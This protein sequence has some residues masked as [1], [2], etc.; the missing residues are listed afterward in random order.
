[1]RRASLTSA[2]SSR[3][4]IKSKSQRSMDA[5]SPCYIAAFGAIN[6]AVRR[7]FS[8][9]LLALFGL[10]FVSP[11]FALGPD[12]NIGLPACCRR[13]GRHQCMTM[14][15]GD[16][17]GS[18]HGIQFSAPVEK[19]P[20]YPSVVA[21]VHPTLFVTSMG[22]VL[23]TRLVSQPTRAAQV[24]SKLHLSQERSR[25]KRGPPVVSSL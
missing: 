17:S 19:C 13:S 1:M 11:L 8:I 9:L 5:A 16:S 2:I 3:V 12:A 20:Y 22:R 24:E 15:H 18:Q 7:L 14:A 10:P 4:L 21:T 25:S 23:F 6:Q